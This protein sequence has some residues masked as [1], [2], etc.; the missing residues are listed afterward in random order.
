MLKRSWKGFSE[1]IQLVV[2]SSYCLSGT[3]VYKVL[4]RV[5]EEGYQT[6]FTASLVPHISQ[7]FQKTRGVEAGYQTN[8][9]A[10]LVPHIYQGS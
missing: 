3:H 9:T 4:T 2:S 8:F 10:C 6:S 1:Q 5:L 7:G